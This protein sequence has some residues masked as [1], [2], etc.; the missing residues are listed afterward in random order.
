MLPHVSALTVGKYEGGRYKEKGAWETWERRDC[1]NK[2]N[3]I[4]L[5]NRD[6]TKKKFYLTTLVIAKIVV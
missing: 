4:K 2:T 1:R 5:R 6:V 3:N